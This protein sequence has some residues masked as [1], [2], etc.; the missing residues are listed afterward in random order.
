MGMN[1]LTIQVGD[2]FFIDG[3]CHTVKRVVL[4]TPDRNRRPLYKL[5]RG[6]NEWVDGDT[7]LDRIL[8]SAC[9]PIQ[10]RL[11]F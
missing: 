11:G 4:D 5:D 9:D 8:R 2:G 6:P 3:I 10:L 7:L 1:E